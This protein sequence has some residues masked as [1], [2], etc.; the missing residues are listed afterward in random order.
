M[1]FAVFLTVFVCLAACPPEVVLKHLPLPDV[2]D[3]STVVD[4]RTL[5]ASLGLRN[6]GYLPELDRNQILSGM[7]NVLIAVPYSKFYSELLKAK[8]LEMNGEPAVSALGYF[9]RQSTYVKHVQPVSS[10]SSSKQSEC[11]H[12]FSNFYHKYSNCEVIVLH[13]DLPKH[14]RDLIYHILK[15]N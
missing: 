12:E 15:S 2:V 14:K 4:R 1:K 3:A 7:K 8:K 5:L 11:T 13:P 10:C 6:F 9:L